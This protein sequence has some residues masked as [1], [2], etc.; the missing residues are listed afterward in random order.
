MLNRFLDS[1]SGWKGVLFVVAWV[2]ALNLALIY[3]IDVLTFVVELI[4]PNGW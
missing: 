2:V 1:M 3:G 4:F